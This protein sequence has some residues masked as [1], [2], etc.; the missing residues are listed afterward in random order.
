MRPLPTPPSNALEILIADDDELACERLEALLAAQGLQALTVSS[1]A[2]AREAMRA[3]HFP[4]VILD[5]NLGDGDGADLCR[6]YRARQT[7]R[8]VRI[9]MLSSQDSAEEAQFALEAGADEFVSKQSGDDVIVERIRRLH[10]IACQRLPPEVST[11]AEAARLRALAECAILDTGAEA[12]FEDVTLIASTLF[13]TPIAAISLIDAN[14][15]W[16]KAKVGIEVDETPRDDAFCAHTIKDADEVLV[17]TDARQDARF[18][19]NPMVTAGPEIRFYAGAPIVT[20]DGFALGAVCV[21]DTQPR[22]LPDEERLALKALARQVV[23]LLEQRRAS[24]EFEN[25]I[26]VQRT[27][28]AEL[29]RREALLRD[30]YENAPIGKA[31]VSL[32]GQWLQVNRAT[33]EILGYEAQ[34]LLRTT[35]QSITHP[36]DLETDLGYVRDML[37]GTIRSYEMEKRYIHKQGHIVWTQL[38]VSLVRDHHDKPVFFATEVQDITRRKRL[39]QSKEEFLATLTDELR[40]P[41]ATLRDSLAQLSN[42][43]GTELSPHTKALFDLSVKSAERLKSLIDDIPS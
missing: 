17:V 1:L 34:E 4:V 27:T 36:D 33:C 8:R 42:R 22:E 3:V 21:I 14:R 20:S 15:Q 41:I 24:K 37:A 13:K 6:E 25:A 10:A 16:F 30:A 7:D 35:F 32:T 28:E 29:R 11:D 2:L 23:T 39:E 38:S 9:L 26:S 40:T 12:A 5:R 19:D 43:V 31:L 18:A